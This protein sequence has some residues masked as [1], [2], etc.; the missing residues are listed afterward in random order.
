M[1]WFAE[2][3]DRRAAIHDS[4]LC[5]WSPDGTITRF[6]LLAGQPSSREGDPHPFCFYDPVVERG[7]EDILANLDEQKA[8]ADRWVRTG[9]MTSG[10]N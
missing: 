5:K 3:D 2:L 10:G 4:T 6:K 9:L 8:A 7:H 1:V